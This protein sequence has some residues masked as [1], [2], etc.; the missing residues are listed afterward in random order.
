MRM[1]MFDLLKRTLVMSLGIGV[2]A[3]ALAF[4]LARVF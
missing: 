4:L 3:A 1:I 2:V